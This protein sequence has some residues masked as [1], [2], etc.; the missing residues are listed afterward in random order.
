MKIDV[1]DL[2]YVRLVDHMGDDLSVVRAARVSHDADPR[3]GIDLKKDEKLICYLADHDH[4]TPFEAVVI[5]MEIKCPIFIARQFHRHRTQSINEV[6]GRYTELPEEY[7][8]PAPEKVGVQSST[9][10]QARVQVWSEEHTAAGKEIRNRIEN[11]C[12]SAF[13]SYQHLIDKGCPRELARSVLP[14]ATYT[15]YYSTMNLRNLAHFIRLREHHTAQWE[16]QQYARAMT[17]IAMSVAP[18]SVGA[19]LEISDEA[20]R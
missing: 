18:I 9:N 6:S 5:T 17:Q 1:L 2:G 13:L 4:M 15:R 14:Q 7:Y 3:T 8:L 10:R 16:A 11:A 19:L 20:Y 12:N